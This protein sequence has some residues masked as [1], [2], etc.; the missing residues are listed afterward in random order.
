MPRNLP[1]KSLRRERG[2]HPTRKLFRA[3]NE[4]PRPQSC[5]FPKSP[6]PTD[7]FRL[8]IYPF[9]PSQDPLIAPTE[10]QLNQ[11]SKIPTVPTALLSNS[12]SKHPTVANFQR[13]QLSQ[14]INSQLFNC[15]LVQLDSRTVGYSWVIYYFLQLDSRTVGSVGLFIILQLDTVGMC[16]FQLSNCTNCPT[17]QLYS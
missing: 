2:Y 14:L 9:Y 1:L 13:S 8:Q 4:P 6:S 3:Q 10:I 16:V 15:P 17:V 12:V 11:L 5:H 7:D